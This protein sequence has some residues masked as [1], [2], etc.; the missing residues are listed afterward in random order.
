MTQPD[1]K[2]APHGY[3]ASGK[4]LAPFGYNVDGSPRKSNRGAR[5]G[6]KGN[7]NRSAGRKPS[8]TPSVS[9][10]TDI[11]RKGMLG[12]LAD[13]F[14]V[15]PLASLSQ[16][17]FIT[18]RL[19]TRQADAL[20]GDAFILSRY[21]PG[22]ADGLIVYSKTKPAAL[23]WLDKLQNNAASLILA[24]ALLSAGKAMAENH[25]SPNPRVAMAGRALAA[26]KIAKMAEAVN[27]EAARLQGQPA[28]EPTSEFSAEDFERAGYNRAM[29]DAA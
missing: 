23:A 24:N 3:D 5:A 28:D 21:M 6:Q 15:N 25:I 2:N 12:D 7:G 13:M 4:A 19:G 16:L 26:Q 29:Q 11:E 14:L 8:V 9:S 22:I 17:P 1:L 20:A 27:A 10:L 18:A